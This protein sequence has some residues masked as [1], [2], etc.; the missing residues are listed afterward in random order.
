MEDEGWETI[1]RPFLIKLSLL[2]TYSI[3]FNVSNIPSYNHQITLTILASLWNETWNT[4]KKSCRNRQEMYRHARSLPVCREI[5]QL[6]KITNGISQKPRWR[7]RSVLHN[8]VI[9]LK[10]F[11]FENPEGSWKSNFGY[12][13]GNLWHFNL[14]LS[15][16]HYAHVHVITVSDVRYDVKYTQS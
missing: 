14:W 6:D 2:E 9:L 11:K 16:L 12:L 1:V 8:D 5:R 4:L 7:S 3:S 15:A 10:T 13:Y